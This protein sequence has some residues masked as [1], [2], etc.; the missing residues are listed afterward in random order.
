MKTFLAKCALLGRRRLKA[1]PETKFIAMNSVLEGHREQL[2][3]KGLH[4]PT[5]KTL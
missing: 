2:S 3:S 1:L 5:E 4:F